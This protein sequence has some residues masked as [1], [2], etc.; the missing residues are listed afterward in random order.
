MGD[1]VQTIKAG[2][3]EIA[4]IFVINKSDREGAE[5]VERE[6]RSMQS[7]AI[8]SDQWTPPIVKTVASE[9]KGISD[10]AAAIAN[11]EHYLQQK[12]LLLKKKITNWRERLLEM[13]RDALMERLLSERLPESEIA[14]LAADIAGH[15]RDPYS[16]VEEIV[17]SFEGSAHR[18]GDH[19]TEPTTGSLGTPDAETRRKEKVQAE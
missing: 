10:L 8:R 15:R 14:R 13:L 7:L 17:G 3:M 9:G 12:D 1:D 11:Y 6:I 19:P 4:D 5:R 18:G 2:I 16:L